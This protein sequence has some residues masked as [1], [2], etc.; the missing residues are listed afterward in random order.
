VPVYRYRVS[1]IAAKVETTSG[2]DAVPTLAA[3]AVQFVGLPPTLAIVYLEI[4]DRNDVVYGGLSGSLARN[5]PAGR[6]GTLTLRMEA[7]GNGVGYTEPTNYAEVDALLRMAG[8]DNVNGVY[9][10]L[11]DGFET[12]SVYV[13]TAAK[14]FKLIGCVVTRMRLIGTV[15]QRCFW[16]FEIQGVMAV[17]PAQTA[18]TAPTLNATIPPV[19]ANSAVLIGAFNYAAGL[20]A[21]SFEVEYAHTIATRPAAGHPD[22]IVGFAIA[23]RRARLNMTIEQV[24]LAT[25]D[26]YAASEQSGAAGGVDTSGSITIGGTANNRLLFEW[27]RWMLDPPALADN[28]GLADWNLAG[29]L[30]ANAL[31]ANSREARLSFT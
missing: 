17:D 10:S 12:G 9:S 3:N 1:A 15:N 30:V 29:E 28:A 5:A 14:L 20:Y 4:G 27:G 6:Y 8:F 18:M 11:D 23:D 7:R 16:E 13:W 31:A 24:A 25:F 21:K 19:F 22:G 26:P 2:V